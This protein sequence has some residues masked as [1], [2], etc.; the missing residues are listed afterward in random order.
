MIIS[1]SRRTDIPC[2][3]GEWFCQRLRQG[4]VYVRNPYHAQQISCISLTPQT[5]DGI[6]FWT[7]NPCSLLSRLEAL[8]DYTFYFQFT[9]NAYGKDIEANLPSKRDVL[10]PMFQALSQKIG[11]ERIVWRYDPIL[12][13]D[14]Y[15]MAYHTKYFA[16]LAKRLADYTEKCTVGFLDM[17]PHIQKTMA[18]CGAST[19]S[20]AEK[21]ALLSEFVSIATAAG[22]YVD[23]C[24]EAVHD[25]ALN[26]PPAHCIDKERLERIGKYRLRL[27]KD[28]NQRPA[29]GCAS[30]IDIGAYH[31][32]QNLCA[33][34]YANGGAASASCRHDPFSPLI[35]GNITSNDQLT[36]RPSSS[37]RDGQFSL[38]DI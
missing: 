7:K 20:A 36:W 29:C 6:V 19:P 14:T 8:Q 2:Y 16:A 35:A 23:T 31:T 17:Y 33:Y 30:S 1:A 15:T 38:F 11:R 21:Q 24:A 26:I 9:L 25:P 32:C 18:A 13:N 12:L 22:I 34:C 4:F 37:C 3:Y 28:K 27:T 10:I 5:V